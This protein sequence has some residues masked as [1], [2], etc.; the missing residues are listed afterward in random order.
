M[1]IFMFD[2]NDDPLGLRFGGV[3][4]FGGVASVNTFTPFADVIGGPVGAML[5]ENDPRPAL[6]ALGPVARL[7]GGL[8]LGFD[9]TKLEKLQRPAGTGQFTE[10]GIASGGGLLPILPGGSVTQSLGFTLNQFPI[11]KRTLQVLPGRTL[12]G[13][14][15]ALGPVNTYLTGE[16]RLDQTTRQRVEKW[17]GT[18]AAVARL[19]S[20]PLVPF[21]TDEQIRKATVAAQARLASVAMQKRLREAMGPP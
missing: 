12:P 16:A 19:F 2:P 18:P 10:T 7:A 15:I 4:F 5:L 8:G 6:N 14:D 13:T 9:V 1:G 17:G 20:V 3:N 11:A 21:K